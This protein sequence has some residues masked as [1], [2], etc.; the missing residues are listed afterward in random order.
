MLPPAP[1]GRFF[2]SLTANDLSTFILHAEG[3]LRS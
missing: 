3:I 1:N 2:P